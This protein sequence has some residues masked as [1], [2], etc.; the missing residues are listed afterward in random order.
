[1][2]FVSA[3]PECLSQFVGVFASFA[4]FEHQICPAFRDPFPG[5]FVRFQSSVHRNELFINKGKKKTHLET[6]TTTKYVYMSICLYVHM[7]I[8]LYVYMSICLYVYMSICLYIKVAKQHTSSVI[9][10]AFSAE[11]FFAF[12][13]LLSI[14]STRDFLS[15]L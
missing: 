8:C 3:P 2:T 7:S 9:L 12:A 6:K 11:N 15:S 5:Q 13:T 4:N 1:M 10:R 14:R